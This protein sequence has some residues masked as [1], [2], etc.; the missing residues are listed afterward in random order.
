MSARP[1]ILTLFS[2]SE[3][4][5]ITGLTTTMQRDWRRR[6]LLP[7]NDRHAKFDVFALAEMA[8]LKMLSDR[9]IG[10]QIA[11]SAAF[12]CSIGIV[13]QALHFIDAYQGDHLRT[14][15][16]LP[17]AECPK[18]PPLP[19]DIANLAKRTGVR[20]PASGSIHWGAQAMF[21]QRHVF[22]MIGAEHVI[23]ARYFIWWADD[24]HIFHVSLD[25]AFSDLSADP[26]YAGPVVV[27][28]LQAIAE[29][30]SQRAGRAFVHVE[31]EV[32]AES[33]RVK[34]PD[35]AEPMHRLPVSPIAGLAGGGPS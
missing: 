3:A 19:E 2:P 28:D 8:T 9:G 26:R 15:E 32:D 21:M 18:V 6:G 35:P 7:T 31:Y 17:E 11:K 10:P 12:W 16:W 14:F 33:G 4:E 34:A 22:T 23:P 30:L 24:S 5:A 27:L 1:Y 29:A 13:W 25:R 20:V